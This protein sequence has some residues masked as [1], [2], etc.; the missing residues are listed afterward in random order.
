MPRPTDTRERLPLR[1]RVRAAVGG[2]LAVLACS[3]PA[4]A[5]GAV[6]APGQVGGSPTEVT[7]PEPTPPPPI[8][9]E[10][11][12]PLDAHPPLRLEPPTVP[13]PPESE[14]ELP[15]P[16]SAVLAPDLR[17]PTGPPVAAPPAQ[18]RPPSST[19]VDPRSR[20]DRPAGSRP[21]AAATRAPNPSAGR[22]PSDARGA[23]RVDRPRRGERR[24][25]PLGAASPPAPARSPAATARGTGLD[26]ALRDL[27]KAAERLV[28][29]IP[30]PVRVALVA[31]LLA[32]LALLAM[33][34]RERR[35]SRRVERLALRDPLT[36]LPNRLA[37]DHRSA[38][39]WER[40]KRYERPI[41]VLVLDIDGF[42]AV[43][44]AHGHRAGDCL[45]RDLARAL[46]GRV[47]RSDLLARLGGDEFV[48]LTEETGRSGL[49]ALARSL[50]QA[51]DGLPVEGLSIGWAQRE[52]DDAEFW[53]V[54]HR[55][56]TAMYRH[57][58]GQ[59]GPAG[60]LDEAD[61]PG[62]PTLAPLQAS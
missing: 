55:A 21:R 4:A 28:S 37:F 45:L 10:P 34:V 27:G 49:E 12:P 7:P 50:E 39:D 29:Y 38:L 9:P 23:R 6:P 52:P 42:K 36:G 11:P 31:G 17:S 1:A 53:D 8:L 47:R 30:L 2:L 20:S 62:E 51:V 54:L 61:P 60:P 33:L 15:H 58:H 44:D 16:E 24:P 59:R 13:Q 57:K 22:G 46:A 3:V 48:V 5:A 43:N 26:D 32:A 18:S 35:R 40:A 19:N 41:G 25:S 14:A 56:D